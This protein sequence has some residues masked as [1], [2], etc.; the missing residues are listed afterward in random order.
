MNPT[1][2]TIHPPVIVVDTR[3]QSP[4][5]FLELASEVGTLKIGDYSARGLTHLI[6]VERKSL[7]DLVNC[8]GNERDRFE[9]EIQHIG[10]Y[11]YRAVV[12]EAT[13]ED[14]EKGEWRSKILP[15]VVTGSVASWSMRYGVP[16]YWCGNHDAGAR[17]T[18]KLIYQAARHVAWEYANAAALVEQGK[19]TNLETVA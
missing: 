17:W 13:F 8:F 19:G 6:A 14:I 7:P 10:S 4:F 3:E 15:Q 2:V 16:F 5:E 1:R 11:R 9:K 12:V 18:E